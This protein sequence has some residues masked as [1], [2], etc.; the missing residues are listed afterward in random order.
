MN[1]SIVNI[2]DDTLTRAVMVINTVANVGLLGSSNS[3]Q[4][5]WDDVAIQGNSDKL[6]SQT[7]VDIYMV[8]V[9]KTSEK[10]ESSF[11]HMVPQRF[12]AK[13]TYDE[14]TR[15]Y[16]IWVLVMLCN[17]GIRET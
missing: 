7:D 4:S 9:P 10:S 13:V 3:N 15:E 6:G 5:P 1:S 12:Y 17:C 2:I 14:Y 11:G 8:P 16:S